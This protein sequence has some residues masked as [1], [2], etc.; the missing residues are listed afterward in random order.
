MNVLELAQNLIKI[1]S[2]TPDGKSEHAQNG[3]EEKLAKWLADF[4]QQNGF[5]TELDYVQPNRPNL[6]VTKDSSQKIKPVIALQAH[7]DTVDVEGMKVDPFGAEI[8]NGNQQNKLCHRSSAQP[9]QVAPTPLKRTHRR[10]CGTS[11]PSTAP[12]KAERYLSVS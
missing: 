4:F 10:R 3:G 1:N 11:L 9:T 5:N 8:K 7:L 12:S 6:F 2:V